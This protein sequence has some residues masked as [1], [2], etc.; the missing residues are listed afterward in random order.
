MLGMDRMCQRCGAPFRTKPSLIARGGGRFCSKRCSAFARKPRERVPAEV[1]FWS[2][3]SKTESCW[4]WTG[5]RSDKGYGIF[6]IEKRK[7]TGAHRYAFD[8]AFGPIVSDL[9]ICHRC[10]NPACVRPG[11][12]FAAPHAVNMVDMAMKGRSG[13]R[14]LPPE[15]VLAIRAEKA[16]GASHRSL[17][18][19]YGVSLSSIKDIIAKRNWG[20]LEASRCP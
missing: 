17:A 10:D 7:L 9:E 11:H 14:R 2:K 19:K 15:K 8:L 4:I 3:V 18:V 1:R 20:W 16:A 5:G 13:Q 12:L 6:A